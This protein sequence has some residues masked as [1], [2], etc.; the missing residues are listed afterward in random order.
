MISSEEVNSCSMNEFFLLRKFNDEA[1][2]D[3]EAGDDEIKVLDIGGGG[4]VKEVETITDN[5]AELVAL[6]EF[7]NEDEVDI[8]VDAENWF[9]DELEDEEK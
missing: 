8:E 4:W 7:V 1:F 6:D 9:K 2:E 3:T 5:E